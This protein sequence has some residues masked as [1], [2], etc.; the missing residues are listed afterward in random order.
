MLCLE[1]RQFSALASLP[2]THQILKKTI[3]DYV[4]KE[5]V[6][7][8]GNLDKTGSYPA[9]QVCSF[10]V[11]VV[12]I[13]SILT[14]YNIIFNYLILGAHDDMNFLINLF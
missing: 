13:C 12:Y 5:I 9:E 7:I 11:K 8:A 1:S 6:P 3:R 14:A 2:E 10:F 4:D